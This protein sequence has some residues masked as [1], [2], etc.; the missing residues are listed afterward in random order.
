[1]ADRIPPHRR[2]RRA[3]AAHAGS[4]RDGRCGAAGGGAVVP[5]TGAAAAD[6]VAGRPDQREQDEL[7]Q[8][9]VVRALPRRRARLPPALPQLPRRR[10]E[11]GHEPAP[12][13]TELTS[14]LQPGVLPTVEGDGLLHTRAWR[15]LSHT[16]G[17]GTGA[18]E[19]PVAATD[20][21]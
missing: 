4:A 10:C 2:E 21:V 3:A 20:E 6:A 19:D 1:A 12:A 8:R 15:T 17:K 5:G 13:T 14:A 16:S 7:A 18:M 9:L 11:R